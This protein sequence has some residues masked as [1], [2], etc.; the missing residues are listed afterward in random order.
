[1]SQGPYHII[2]IGLLLILCYL[3]S[4]LSVRMQILE[5]A[6][7][8]RFWNILLLLFFFSVSL[9][10]LFLAIK[11]NYK[12]NIPWIDPVMRWHVDTGVGLA[13][14]AVFHFTWHLRYYGK[15][16]SRRTVIPSE[17]TMSPFL[18]FSTRQITILF[19]MLGFITMITQLVLLKEYIKSLHGNEL[20]IGIFLAVWMILTAMGARAGSVYRA[21]IY[22]PTLMRILLLLAGFP[23]FI[24]L[25]LIWLIRLV[26]LPGIIPGILASVSYM[27]LIIPFT[28][29]SGFLFAYLSRS[30]KRDR[31]DVTY[32]MLDSLGSLM[33]GVVFGLL[34]VFL[35]SNIQVIVLLFL[36]AVVMV[37]AF[38]NYPENTAGKVIFLVTGIVISGILMIPGVR[39]SVESM[40][41]RGEV[42]LE[43]KDTPH[44]NL[45]F[46]ERDGQVTGYL[47]MNPVITS[48]DPARCEEQVHYPALQHPAPTSFLLIG[49]DLAGMYDEVEKYHPKTVDYCEANRWMYRLEKKYLPLPEHHRFID[50][51]GR[52]WLMKEDTM[53][54]DVIIS[55]AGEPLTIG[56]NRYFTLEFFRQAKSRL[57]EGG[58]F[59]LH[60]PAGGTYVN[61]LGSDQL[62]ITYCTLK[63]VFRNVTVVPGYATYFLAS[64]HPLSLDY[65]TLLEEKKI[66]TTYVHPDYL[67]LTRLTFDS[68]MIMERIE[69]TDARINT[70]FWPGLFYKS[71]SGWNLKTD[72]KNLVYIGLTGLLLFLL[73]LFSYSR[74]KTGMFV[75]GFTG[76]G[77]Q[78][79]LILVMQSLYGFAYLVTPLMITLFM[80]GL[81]TGTAACKIIWRD[82]ALSKTTGLIWIMALLSAAAV[83]LMKTEQIFSHRWS[84]M[85]VLSLL[86]FLPGVIVGSVYGIL[87]ALSRNEAAASI[88][89][90]YSADLAGAAL[91]TMIP[92]LFLVPLI[93]VSNTFILFCGF[94]VAAGLYIQTRGSKKRGGDG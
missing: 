65:P 84:G 56:W 36:F 83:I 93:G 87:L 22:G 67:D 37:I 23:M 35:L 70:D 58:I 72:N 60:L 88:G 16:I 55:G 3:F 1:M 26:V 62:A 57:S 73:L 44:G 27:S 59:S 75:A 68:D 14:V 94:N 12:L 15:A 76:A 77:M 50:M 31:A 90:L 69:G 21:R 39:N 17:D 11:A 40:R 41:F 81:V 46:A 80:G 25:L 48:Y 91:G 6:R 20:V 5:Q 29:V 89:K 33:G 63:K 43:T 28:L 52:S 32:Y 47:D 71:L 34:L 64:D 10:G 61:E 49:G 66:P 9:L 82:P 54:Y 13:V 74:Q 86:N 18:E 30:V 2:P 19:A 53:R 38:F 45:T 78:I 4:L 24:Y 8:R 92:P 85:I 42:I 51:D 79:L 7:H